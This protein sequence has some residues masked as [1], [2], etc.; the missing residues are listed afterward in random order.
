MVAELC[1]KPRQGYEE[2]ITLALLQCCDFRPMI[3]K[4]KQL[5]TARQPSTTIPSHHS[6]EHA[7]RSIRNDNILVKRV[8]V[9]NAVGGDLVDRCLQRSDHETSHK[10]G[11]LY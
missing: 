3:G 11:I 7:N 10:Q 5:C 9:A 6:K 1:H 2:S 8:C 4:W